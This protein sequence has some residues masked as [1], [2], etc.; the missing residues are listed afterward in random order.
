MSRQLRPGADA[1]GCEQDEGDFRTPV[2]SDPWLIPQ[3]VCAMTGRTD[4]AW[5]GSVL[6]GRGFGTA[7]TPV[8]DKTLLGRRGVHAGPRLNRGFPGYAVSWP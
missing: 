5:F 3:A 8:P 6:S 2:V 1:F 7:T 4:V